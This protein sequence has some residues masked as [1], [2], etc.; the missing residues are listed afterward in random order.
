MNRSWIRSYPN[1][2]CLYDA[3]VEYISDPFNLPNPPPELAMMQSLNPGRNKK[4]ESW[5]MIPGIIEQGGSDCK[6]L[7]AW[8]C[9]ELR[10]QNVPCRPYLKWKY[11]P[12][13]TLYHVLVEYPDA[14]GHYT[15]GRTTFEDPSRELGMGRNGR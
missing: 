11:S 10:Q 3:G 9:A 1:T 4:L 2:P 8:R 12:D 13:F 5:T 14:Q 15:K 7:T 6:N